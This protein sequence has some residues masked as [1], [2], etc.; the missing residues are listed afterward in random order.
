MLALLWLSSV[1]AQL[2]A[3]MQSGC[4]CFSLLLVP[5]SVFIVILLAAVS[6]AVLFLVFLIARFAYCASRCF[7]V[8]VIGVVVSSSSS[9]HLFWLRFWFN[10][11]GKYAK[12]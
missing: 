7:I 5:I 1:C 11:L 3:T 10:F 4:G 9:V 8:P 6:I 2:A 12:P